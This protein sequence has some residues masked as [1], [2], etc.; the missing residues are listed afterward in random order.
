M[1]MGITRA[2]AAMA[3][4]VFLTAWTIVALAADPPGAN[5]PSP[6]SGSTSLANAV[7]TLEGATGGRVLEIRYD[8]AGTEG[9]YSAVIAAKGALT[10]ER[11]NAHTNKVEDISS[12][13]PDWMLGWERRADIASIEKTQVPLPK[14]IMNAEKALAGPAVA[15]GLAKPLS[16][17][18]SVLAYN[19]AVIHDGHPQRIAID[20]TTN[21]V[22][23]DSSMFDSWAIQ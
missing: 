23:A 21:E 2:L 10:H 6:G 11:I 9:S 8:G 12:S 22:I 4:G 15:A 17:G 19:V 18:N 5:V 1:T 20:A 16:P 7:A 14:A 13:K 3:A